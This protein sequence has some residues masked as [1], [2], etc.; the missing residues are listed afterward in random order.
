M[1]SAPPPI[2]PSLAALL[3]RVWPPLPGAAAP[4]RVLGFGWD[5]HATL[6][7]VTVRE[8]RER[9]L[10]LYDVVGP[11]M[12]PLGALTA[13]I[14]ADA[15]RVVTLFSPDRLGEGFVAE[16]CNA[17]RAT[18]AGDLWFTGPM[19]RGPLVGAGASVMLPPLS[20]T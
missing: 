2:D 13:A 16:P 6:D 12:P 19:A 10:G 1:P 14:G 18:A 4:A 15:D 8:V 7:V 20:R 11:A 9:T 3:G 5:Y 17:A